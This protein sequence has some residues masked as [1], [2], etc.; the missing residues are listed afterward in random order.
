M[1][2]AISSAPSHVDSN[3]VEAVAG[4]G[5]SPLTARGG[6]PSAA[7]GSGGRVAG[8]KRLFGEMLSSAFGASG[9]ARVAGS[10][11]NALPVPA[12]QEREVGAGIR[13]ITAGG[14]DRPGE[15][16][17]FAFAVSQGL[18]A[19]LVA[20][21]L[22]PG[23]FAAKGLGEPGLSASGEGFA[24]LESEGAAPGQ[25]PPSDVLAML[26][27]GAISAQTVQAAQGAVQGTLAPTTGTAPSAGLPA[28]AV[29]VGGEGSIAAE[30]GSVLGVLGL[31]GAAPTGVGVAGASVFGGAMDTEGLAVQAALGEL[32]LRGAGV[33]AAGLPAAAPLGD[34]LGVATGNLGP[35]NP[36]AAPPRM[37]SSA[38]FA[39]AQ[40]ILGGGVS[41][42]VGTHLAE[43][44]PGPVASR[45]ADLRIQVK[46]AAESTLASASTGVG[47]ALSQSASIPAQWVL[48]GTGAAGSAGVRGVFA[49]SA[50]SE[51]AADALAEAA[52][53]AD[54]DGA[55]A[56][57]SDGHHRHQSA[58]TGSTATDPIDLSAEAQRQA[59][60][61]E[62][63]GEE[64]LA[65]RFAEGVAQRMLAAVSANSW[66]LQ[67]EL[68]PAH[69]GHVSIEMS[70]QQGQLEAVFD[71]GQASTRSLISENLDRLRQDLQRA[72]MNVAHL[73]LN[74]GG[75]AG[76]GGKS[77]PREREGQSADAA[78][79][80]VQEL[81]PVTTGLRSRV[82]PD[83]LDVTV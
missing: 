44:I 48:L 49:G 82:G 29:G 6:D 17:L 61:A 23:F 72:G 65:R 67:I 9:G 16:A 73:G 55:G 46:A 3:V 71:A 33:D 2:N 81:S 38:A 80:A 35:L 78:D 22:W 13:L 12:L 75:G 79:Q 11:G 41:A 18:D 50:P 70:M 8:G 21:V 4:G 10:S 25:A 52:A 19:S 40:S 34:P 15:E 76:S 64:G 37:D 68:K 83:G 47:A 63:E 69:L 20:S 27:A 62:G 32:G 45:I 54:I 43:S 74:F 42:G 36:G 59:E 26:L 58:K 14:A 24:G 5:N 39:A 51:P 31:I 66:K 1:M 60:R 57:V 53:G 77:T 7:T 56:T 30:S 28:G